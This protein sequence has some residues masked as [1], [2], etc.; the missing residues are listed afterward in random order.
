VRPRYFI[1]VRPEKI[2]EGKLKFPSFVKL[3]Q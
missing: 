1:V 2:A 3:S